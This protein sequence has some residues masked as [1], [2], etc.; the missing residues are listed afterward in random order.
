MWMVVLNWLQISQI[1]QMIQFVKHVECRLWI[2]E[3]ESS[4][5]M[6][7]SLSVLL[8]IQVTLAKGFLNT[9]V[10]QESENITLDYEVIDGIFSFQLSARATE[11]TQ[12]GLV[13]SDMVSSEHIRLL[14]FYLIC[15]FFKD[16]PK[17]GFITKLDGSTVNL[18]KDKTNTTG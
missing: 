15:L 7:A 12:L 9:K 14:W 17:E 4:V 13:F 2:L 5:I 10:F 3:S 8:T 1:L 18:S 6:Q 11:E 16:L